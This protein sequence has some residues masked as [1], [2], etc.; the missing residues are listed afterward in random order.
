MSLHYNNLSKITSF[1]VPQQPASVGN[2]A[3]D[4]RAQ[5][6]PRSYQYFGKRGLDLLLILLALPVVLPVVLCLAVFVALDGSLPF[7][8]Q[9]RV[10]RGGR[11]YTMWKLRSMVPDAD[12]KLEA[13]LAQDP[14]ARAEWDSTQKLKCDPRI[15]R[16]GRVLR[17]SSLDELPQLWNVLKG[18]M[19][20]VGPRP[21]M[22]DQQDLYPGSAYR[23]MRPGITGLWQV[24]E[25]NQSTFADRA[26]YDAAYYRELSFA[27]DLKVLFATVR[28][29]V[30]AT[31]Y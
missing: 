19:S 20:L 21:M 9:K 18:D 7:Y 1:L 5:R 16:F 14:V 27:T 22:P 24:S 10:G 28:V 2:Q 30:R 3:T 13:C 26:R 29:V 8:S 15:T 11:I 17:K 23:E 31:G 6:A 25:R 12:A 4:K